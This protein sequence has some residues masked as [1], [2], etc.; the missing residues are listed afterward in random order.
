ME[1][2]E[3]FTMEYIREINAI[4][5]SKVKY[6]VLPFPGLDCYPIQNT[7]VDPIKR[8]QSILRN[9]AKTVLLHK[10]CYF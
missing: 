5:Y 1:I 9:A 4:T 7:E 10:P 3:Q 6:S 8:R 2:A